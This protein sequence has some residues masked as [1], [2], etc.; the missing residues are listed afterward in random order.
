MGVEEHEE[1]GKFFEAV[2]EVLHQ[3]LNDA[4]YVEN[5][6]SNITKYGNI[7]IILNCIR[8]KLTKSIKLYHHHFFGNLIMEMMMILL[9]EK[10][11]VGKVN[12]WTPNAGHQTQGHQ[13]QKN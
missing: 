3:K 1:A 4:T 12:V 8:M 11:Y 2:N 7:W 6:K 10:Q 5:N 9:M 13:T